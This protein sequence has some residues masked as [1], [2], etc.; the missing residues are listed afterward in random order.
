MPTGSS[1]LPIAPSGGFSSGPGSD[2]PLAALREPVRSLYIHVPFCFHKCHYCDFYS[3][4]DT[5]DRQPEFVERLIAELRAA[6]AHAARVQGAGRPTLD[7][8]FVG[9]GTPSL[10]KP[11]LWR[12]LLDALG[13]L[14][15]TAPGHEFTVECNPETVS[16]E[17]MEVLVAGGVTRVSIGAQ[18]S[19]AAHLKTLERWHDP[20]NVE[21][22]LRLAADAGIARR[23]IDLIFA[24]PGQTLADWEGDLDWAL[25]LAGGAGSGE[26]GVEHVSC[27]ALTYE[28]N[29]AMTRRLE[30]GE[31]VP[32]PDDLEVAMQRL[33]ARRLAE[34]GL[35]RYE[36][37]NFALAG[38]ECRHNMAYWRQ[39]QWLAC[40]PSASGHAAGHR[41]KNVPRLADWMSG[42]AA[43]GGYSPMVDHETPDASR[44]LAERIMTGL[45]LREGLPEAEILGR[46]AAL[47]AENPLRRAAELQ[48][49]RGLLLVAGG[50]WTLTEDG[51]LFADGIASDLMSSL[52]GARR[53]PGGGP[54]AS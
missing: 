30:R 6:S 41:W 1:S 51:L 5:Q 24:I 18:S 29:T 39:D 47:G 23:S 42:V 8:I 36:V 33:T 9:G 22:A 2:V 3:F 52:G 50:R 14:F 12:R 13:G 10:L 4:V 21:R 15:E 19:H 37:S 48:A 44:A 26:G 49:R 16:A 45:R 54:S 40:G 17:L 25:G 53:G 35:E 34:A 31:F 20:A 46:A 27:Y 11:D 28:P 32:A 43:R 38:A 7:T